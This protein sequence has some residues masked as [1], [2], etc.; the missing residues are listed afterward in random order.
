MSSA[1]APAARGP[2][3]SRLEWGLDAAALLFLP[4]L[5]L[6]SHGLA[7][8]EAVAGLFALGLARRRAAPWRDLAAPA[9]LFAGLVLWGAV[10]AAWAPVPWR[11]L[12]I[13]FRL[14][15]LF[16]AGL[17]LAAAAGVVAEPARLVRCFLVG[18]ALGIVI[19][20][21]ERAT[22][23]L[24]TRP[25]FVRGFVAPQLNQASDTLSILALPAAATLYCWRRRA[26]AAVLLLAS[27]ATIYGLVG[28]AAQA[29]FAVALVI[30]LLCYRWR[31][32]LARL[33][34]VLSILVVAAAPLGFP[35]LA[36]IEPLMRTA[37]EAKS[38]V[39]HRLLIWS[40]AGERIA[41]KPLF[42]WGL[43]SSRAIPGGQEWIRPGEP[44]LPLHPHNLPLQLWL[45]LGVPGAVLGA[46]IAARLWTALAAADWPR[47]FAAACAGGLAAA[48]SEALATYGA[49]EE[50]WIGTLWFALFLVLV[51]ARA[52]APAT[53]ERAPSERG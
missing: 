35:K 42:G 22:G 34:A 44:W 19:L 27:A 50:W 11:S 13:A 51:M 17:A 36:G 40:F 38:S 18:V 8:L 46:L 48:A 29:S 49:W 7:P 31:R 16:A 39:S 12:L 4:V 6:A 20:A 41:E 47:L 28:T 15:G 1:Q 52:A 3:P 23:G 24:L 21:V 25:F 9:A 10:S 32:P 30:A 37:E 26:L 33:A 2:V 53:A 5:A 45:E 43:D 14:A